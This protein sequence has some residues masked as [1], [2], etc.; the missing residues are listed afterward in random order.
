MGWLVWI[1]HTCFYGYFVATLFMMLMKIVGQG[2]KARSR[3][4]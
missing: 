2:L 1:D 3:W 4:G